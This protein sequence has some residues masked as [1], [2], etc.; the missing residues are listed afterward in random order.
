MP[1]P[2]NSQDKLDWMELT[3]APPNRFV[4]IANCAQMVDS[5][6]ISFTLTIFFF[7]PLDDFH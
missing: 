7:G 3:V 2:Q 4:N 1:P 6:S 5:V